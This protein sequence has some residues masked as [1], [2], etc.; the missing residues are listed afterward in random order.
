VRAIQVTRGAQPNFI[1]ACL[2]K[3]Q[4]DNWMARTGG[5]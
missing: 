4:L 2:N 3:L 5:P 1:C